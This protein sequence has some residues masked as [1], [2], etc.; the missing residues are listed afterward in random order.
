MLERE[1]GKV[2]DSG[3]VVARRKYAE[4]TAFVAWSV[5]MIDQRRHGADRSMPQPSAGLF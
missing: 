4:H 3:D 5:A 1:Q 2:G